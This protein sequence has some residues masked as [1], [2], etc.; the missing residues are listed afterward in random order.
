[1][2]RRKEDLVTMTQSAHTHKQTNYDI[3]K[4]ERKDKERSSRATNPKT[5]TTTTIEP[6]AFECFETEN[7]K[8]VSFEG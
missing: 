7:F 3:T 1:V 6:I 4:D 5:T 8:Y 2:W